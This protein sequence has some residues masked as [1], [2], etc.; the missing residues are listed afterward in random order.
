MT[1][2]RPLTSTAEEVA[3]EELGKREE[4]PQL[5]SLSLYQPL[6]A[7]SLQTLPP[8]VERRVSA[9][10]KIAKD[11]TRDEHHDT[12]EQHGRGGKLTNP[13]GAEAL[14]KQYLLVYAIVM[15]AL[16]KASSCDQ[17]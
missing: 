4:A 2:A 11:K 7:A 1:E 14:E 15:G 6:E 10:K 8:L 17:G 12:L 3:R 9:A 16:S 5:L 13:V